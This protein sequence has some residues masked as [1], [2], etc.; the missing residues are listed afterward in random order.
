MV[1]K[2]FLTRSCWEKNWKMMTLAKTITNQHTPDKVFLLAS[3]FSK[4]PQRPSLPRPCLEKFE[5]W[6]PLPG[7]S[8]IHIFLIRF[9]S[10]LHFFQNGPQDIPYQTMFGKVWKM[11]TLA[12]TI[13]N[14]HIPAKLFALPYILQQS[15]G[16]CLPRQNM[17]LLG[18]LVVLSCDQGIIPWQGILMHVN[19]LNPT[20]MPAH[21]KAIPFKPW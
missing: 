14:P 19:A 2:T 21:Y 4:W 10:W 16:Q 12:S 13:T 3:S 5:K 7:P 6:R 20:R 1:P 11:K 8:K 17:G 9:F 18:R 15:L